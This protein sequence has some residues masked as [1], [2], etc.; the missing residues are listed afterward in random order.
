MCSYEQT[1]LTL[2]Y[3]AFVSE[4]SEAP[5]KWALHSH[6]NV[7]DQFRMNECLIEDFFVVVVRV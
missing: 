1:W 6:S 5:V 2:Y 4:L 3:Y 7:A